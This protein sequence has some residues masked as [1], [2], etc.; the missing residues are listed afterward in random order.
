[1]NS[2]VVRNIQLGTLFNG[3]C[4][5]IERTPPP[6]PKKPSPKKRNNLRNLTRQLFLVNRLIPNY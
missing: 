2:T 4:R 3:A 6:P 5:Y 1:M